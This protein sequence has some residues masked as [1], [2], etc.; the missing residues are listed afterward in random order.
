MGILNTDRSVCVRISLCDTLNDVVGTSWV[1][2]MDNDNELPV[3]F[4]WLK[5]EMAVSPL[6]LHEALLHAKVRFKLEYRKCKGS[7][8]RK[9]YIFALGIFLIIL[10]LTF[11]F[12]GRVC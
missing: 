1:L 7:F 3:G 2:L 9:M 11:C 4:G 5:V 12:E 10:K 6:S 8:L